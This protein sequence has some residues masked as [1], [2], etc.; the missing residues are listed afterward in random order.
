MRPNLYR[1]MIDIFIS[2]S[3]PISEVGKS[4]AENAVQFIPT[5]DRYA[6]NTIIKCDD[7]INCIIP[8]GG[9]NLIRFVVENAT[10]TLI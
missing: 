10:I 8:R 7:N 1:L 5:T 2:S 6:L 9:D 4:S 3:R